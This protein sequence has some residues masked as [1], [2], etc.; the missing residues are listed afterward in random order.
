MVSSTQGTWGPS[1]RYSENSAEWR[2]AR[3]MEAVLLDPAE[4][5]TTKVHRGLQDHNL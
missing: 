2:N 3:S 5:V 4:L 1:Q